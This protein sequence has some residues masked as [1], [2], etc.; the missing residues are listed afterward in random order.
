M[1]HD[2]GDSRVD[3]QSYVA[4][5]IERVGTPGLEHGPKHSDAIDPNQVLR[6]FEIPQCSALLPDRAVL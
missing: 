6:P 1:I 2:I 3:C 5:V 4:F